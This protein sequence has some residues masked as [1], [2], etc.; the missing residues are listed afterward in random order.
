MILLDGVVD[1]IRI[2]GSSREI[3]RRVPNLFLGNRIAREM[4]GDEGEE[5]ESKEAE[6]KGGTDP[7]AHGFLMVGKRIPSEI[8]FG[9]EET[10]WE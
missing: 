5:N 1:K 8:I 7:S 2:L 4:E 3:V 6:D 10:E 9:I